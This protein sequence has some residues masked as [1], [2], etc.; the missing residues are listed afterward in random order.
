MFPVKKKLGR[1]LGPGSAP[2][3]GLRH[4][5]G[6]GQSQSAQNL[7]DTARAYHIFVW[8]ISYIM[9]YQMGYVMDISYIMP[10]SY[11]ISHIDDYILTHRIHGAGILTYELGLFGKLL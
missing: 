2:G 10:I 1:C 6:A 4:S 11:Y 8:D 9:A 3:R 5:N 7:E